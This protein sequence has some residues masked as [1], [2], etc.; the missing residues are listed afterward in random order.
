[1]G[2]LSFFQSNSNYQLAQ[3]NPSIQ[4]G[5]PIIQQAWALYGRMDQIAFYADDLQG[6]SNPLFFI[7]KVIGVRSLKTGKIYRNPKEKMQDLYGMTWVEFRQRLYD[8]YM[9]P[10]N[11]KAIIEDAFDRAQYLVPLR[12][13]LLLDQ[14]VS[15]ARIFRRIAKGS[16]N[17]IWF[18]FQTIWPRIFRP[19]PI[20]GKVQHSIPEKGYAKLW[21]PMT[22][23]TQ[24]RVRLLYVTKGG[25]GL[26]QLND[27]I[28]ENDPMVSIQK[29]VSKTLANYYA[30]GFIRMEVTLRL[31]NTGGIPDTARVLKG[32]RPQPYQAWAQ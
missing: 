18:G 5:G 20:R 29:E 13:G 22:K 15:R 32:V 14:L 10:I 16:K 9:D 31:P 2:S 7:T 12:S 6:K 8:F 24:S 23:Y 4:S 19:R 26:Y 17:R 25:Y 27:P 21:T 3:Y 28:S 1:M 11:D 30:N